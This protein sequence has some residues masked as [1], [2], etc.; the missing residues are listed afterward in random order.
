MAKLS[1][2]FL[3]CANDFQN[4][5]YFLTSN[6]YS[7]EKVKGSVCLKEWH[8]LHCSRYAGLSFMMANMIKSLAGN[9]DTQYDY[10]EVRIKPDDS[11]EISYITK[12]CPCNI[13]RFLAH[14]S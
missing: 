2:I 7:F 9:F 8:H 12:T 3:S 6:L 13:L 10:N 11:H 14:L 1:L 5:Q 4:V